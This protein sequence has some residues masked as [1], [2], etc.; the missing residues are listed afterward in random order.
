MWV[1]FG[2]GDGAEGEFTETLFLHP[3]AHLEKLYKL[4]QVQKRKQATSLRM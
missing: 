1:A 2:R 3:K 4:G